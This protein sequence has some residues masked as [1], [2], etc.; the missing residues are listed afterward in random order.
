MRNQ[1]RP[2]ISTTTLRRRAQ[3][4]ADIRAFFCVRKILEVDVPV[5]GLT[6]VTDLYI[7]SPCLA[8]PDFGF[9]Q[10]SPEYYMKRLLAADSGS[11]YC[12]G[13]AF[14]SREFGARHY[15]EFT[16]LEWYRT[17]WDEHRLMR[18]VFDLFNSLGVVDD[19]RGYVKYSYRELFFGQTN[20]DPHLD[21]MDSIVALASKVANR[22]MVDE[23]RTTCLNLIFS[24]VIEPSLPEGVVFIYDYPTCMA[25]LA[26]ITEVGGV[27]VARRFEVFCDQVEIG[28][29]YYEL[30]DHDQ[31]RR[32][33]EE[34]N[35]QRKVSGKPTVKLDERLLAALADGL[36]SCSGVA[37]GVD[38]LLMKLLG[39]ENIREVLSF[40]DIDGASGS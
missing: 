8:D 37:I 33:F 24:L 31:L 25:A 13:K 22:D 39:T 21:N 20:V 17:D 36:P 23:N 38:R 5:L 16:M 40:A 4:L 6:G 18:E 3:F 19:D 9:L 28:N 10:S 26:E 12:L 11:I 30:T 34:D 29:G 14:R 1:W 32:R 15:P 2:S 35:N 7:D 27:T